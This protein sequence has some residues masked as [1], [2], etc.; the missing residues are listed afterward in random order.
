VV[1]RGAT[2][3]EVEASREIGLAMASRAIGYFL[4]AEHLHYGYWPDGL[5]VHVRNVARAQELYTAELVG[6]FP[7]GVE[8]VLDVGCGSGA[9]ALQLLARGYRVECVTPP[10]P[11]AEL[12]AEALGDDVPLHL[13]PFQR[14]VTDRRYDLL[15]FSESLLFIRPLDVALAR[16]CSLLEPGGHVL[17]CDLF[18]SPP[19]ESGPVGAGSYHRGPIGGGHYRQELQE[20]LE[21]TPL[22]PVRET[23]ITD[24][25]A[26]SFDVIAQAMEVVEPIYRLWRERLRVRHPW[27]DRLGGRLLDLEKYERKYFGGRY[28]AENFRRWKRYLRLL[29]RLP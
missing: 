18:R 7:A 15:L 3:E 20:A 19:P 24:R 16:A 5:E 25:I 11:L 9:T 2:D 28:S 23:D 10:G 22:E 26:P 21:A 27:M 1:E 8:S 12:A 29:L 6:D 17:I 14:F 4:G 13:T